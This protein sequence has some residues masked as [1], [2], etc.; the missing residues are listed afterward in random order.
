MAIT[1][2]LC[3][4]LA[5]R[6][7]SCPSPVGGGPEVRAKLR[8][9]DA[10]GLLVDKRS[11]STDISFAGIMFVDGRT[12]AARLSSG[13]ADRNPSAVEC[14]RKVCSVHAHRIYKCKR[15]SK[16]KITF[17]TLTNVYGGAT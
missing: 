8:T 6:D 11:H 14:F 10:K 7:C 13:F 15:H 1:L 9:G 4:G 12:L 17:V 3:Y 2:G 16:R 5:R